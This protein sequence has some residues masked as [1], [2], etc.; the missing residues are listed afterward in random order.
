M[1]SAFALACI[2]SF[3]GVGGSYIQAKA[4]SGITDVLW[5][6][7]ATAWENISRHALLWANWA[8]AFIEPSLVGEMFAVGNSAEFAAYMITEGYTEEE[9]EECVHG[10]GGHVRDGIS[11]D[12]DGNVTYS[13]EV[14]DLFHG[15]IVD[16]LDSNSGYILFR[17]TKAND[18][19]TILYDTKNEVDNFITTINNL[20]MAYIYYS[21]SYTYCLGF[22]PPND[23][24]ISGDGNL[25]YTNIGNGG[26]KSIYDNGQIVNI[27]YID[28]NWER[29][30]FCKFN[31]SDGALVK[32]FSKSYTL[33][34]LTVTTSEI[35]A[36]ALQ[37]AEFGSY[38]Y[39]KYI[40]ML[41]SN[42]GRIIKL[43]HDF[44]K[45]KQFDVGNQM[46]YVTDS[47]N[48][49]DSTID[50]ST[51]ITSQEYAYY[52][53][54]STTIYQTIQNNIDNSG[55]SDL[56]EK[57]VQDIVDAAVQEI[58][59]SI[60]NS[61]NDDGGGNDSGDS[62]N[63]GNGVGDLVG[64]IGKLFDTILSLIGKV[65]GVV[66]DFTQSILDL[67]T[68]FTDFTDGFSNFLS[69]AFSFIPQEIW[70]VIQVGL[71]LMIPLAV[72]KFLRK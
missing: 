15:Y 11:M 54:N 24:L 5:N 42:D 22:V 50:N 66:A 58:K 62:D 1:L 36:G 2:I 52:N 10:G 69:G 68:G 19:A 12:D 25:T 49:Y 47:F 34:D 64:G 43:W 28:D 26:I 27:R 55:N 3:S 46:Y 21:T 60:T 72:I 16:Y 31:T 18:I 45:Y 63:G 14:S 35:S 67:F 29:H 48:N 33:S 17:T 7:N 44:E 51:T 30:Y 40:Q 70:N 65:M 41:V 8:G 4:S 38:S 9:A 61:G 6:D 23:L 53:D 59:D 32:D 57:D 37:Y 71:S 13:D 56:T 39:P 20:G